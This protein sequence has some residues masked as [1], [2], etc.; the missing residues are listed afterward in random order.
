MINTLEN[1]RQKVSVIFELSADGTVLYF[2]NAAD[3]FSNKL[4]LSPV[5]R[6]FLEIEF[7]ENTGEFWRRFNNFFK[8]HD[9]VENFKYALQVEN[10][11]IQTRIMLMRV[12]ERSNNERVQSVIVDIRS[13]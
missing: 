7:F 11:W 2:R 10:H 12:I 8:S 4:S 3:N 13:V 6:N 9:A 5:G 1:V